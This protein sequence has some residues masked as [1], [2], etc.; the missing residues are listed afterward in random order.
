MG[1]LIRRLAYWVRWRRHAS[2]LDEEMAF[3]RSMTGGRSFGNVA[4]AREDARQVWIAPRLESIWQDLRYWA[5]SLRRE[6]GFAVASLGILGAAIGLNV[7]LFTVFTALMQR[8]W[9]V[10][11]A[12]RVV[13]VVDADMRNG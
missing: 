12:A 13:S 3:H 7:S 10:A 11:D 1:R 9:P 2:E 5:R 6:P 4:L 8:P